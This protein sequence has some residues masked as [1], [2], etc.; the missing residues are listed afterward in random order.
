VLRAAIG[1]PVALHLRSRPIRD[2]LQ[3]LRTA[4]LGPAAAG[5][6]GCKTIADI[7]RECQ[8]N[9]VV[10]SAPARENGD[11]AAPPPDLFVARVECGN[12]AEIARSVD[13]FLRGMDPNDVAALAILCRR[14]GDRAAPPAPIELVWLGSKIRG[15]ELGEPTIYDVAPTLLH[16]LGIPAG[17]DMPGR[18]L[19][20]ALVSARPERRIPTWETRPIA[21]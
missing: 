10:A 5:A 18:V 4:R 20:E 2:W 14:D 21:R 9:A 19:T 1:P 7:A 13:A 8:R 17:R 12:A 16:I 3:I 15:A 11:A 6:I